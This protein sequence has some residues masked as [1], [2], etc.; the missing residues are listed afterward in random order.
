MRM[1]FDSRVK[2]AFIML[3]TF[4]AMASSGRPT[5]ADDLPLGIPMPDKDIALAKEGSEP[6]AAVFPEMLL[7]LTVT[8]P[9]LA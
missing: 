2:G 8:V 5:H 4:A 7:L 3:M 1:D 6:R 9:P